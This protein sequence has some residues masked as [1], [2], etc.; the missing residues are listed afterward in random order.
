MGNENKN[1]AETKRRNDENLH[2]LSTA[3]LGCLA[4]ELWITGDED[5][6]NAVV[7][8]GEQSI[9]VYMEL[10]HE[11][12]TRIRAGESLFKAVDAMRS[13]GWIARINSMTEG[14]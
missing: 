13:A 11:L 1:H 2:L 4:R 12:E 6:A 14:N 9:K 3:M 10:T 5:A 8:G 7:Q